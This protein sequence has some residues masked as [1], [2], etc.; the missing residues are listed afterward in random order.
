MSRPQPDV[1]PRRDQR[2]SFSF[3]RGK[4]RVVCDDP[5]ANSFAQGDVFVVSHTVAKACE[6]CTSGCDP[7]CRCQRLH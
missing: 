1:V 3:I 7:P 4:L 5:A 2:Q 6:V